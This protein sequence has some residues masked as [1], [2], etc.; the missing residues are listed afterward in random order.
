MKEPSMGE[1]SMSRKERE[2]FL[3]KTHVGILC[4][5]EEDGR[6]PLAVP[7]WYRYEPGGEVH[8]ITEANSRKAKLLRE[9][10]RA[11]LVA[12]N[13]SLPYRYVTVEGPVAIVREFDRVKEIDEVAYRYLGRELGEA[14]LAAEDSASGENVLVTIRPERWGSADFAKLGLR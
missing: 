2:E 8:F 5:A 4:V 13:E 9:A 12:Q 11:T 14:Y 10:G 6:A 7:I 1:L 3:A